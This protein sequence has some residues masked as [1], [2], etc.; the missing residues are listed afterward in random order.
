MQ[1]LNKPVLVAEQLGRFNQTMRLTASM[2]LT[3]IA[4]GKA[5]TAA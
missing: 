2:D 3:H 5:G 4:I 1:L